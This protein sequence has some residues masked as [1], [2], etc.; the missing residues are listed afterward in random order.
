LPLFSAEIEKEN[1]D[2]A[3]LR[4]VD[5]VTPEV[6]A[7]LIELHSPQIQPVTRFRLDLSNRDAT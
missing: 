1:G 7:T 6:I 4:A 2:L 3:L 5:R